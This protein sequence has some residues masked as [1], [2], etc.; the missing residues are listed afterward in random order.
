MNSDWIRQIGMNAV[1]LTAFLLLV[2][3]GIAALRAQSSGADHPLQ[4]TV[5]KVDGRYTIAMPGSS[6]PALRAG[7]GV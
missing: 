2:G 1:R 3:S 6:S 4:I 5:N 7:V